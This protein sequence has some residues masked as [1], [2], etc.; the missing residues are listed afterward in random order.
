VAGE[1]LGRRPVEERGG[2]LP[3]AGEAALRRRRGIER[4]VD[5]GPSA[6]HLVQGKLDAGAELPG[7]LKGVA[8]G[9]EDLDQRMADGS[10]AGWSA[11]TSRSKGRSWCA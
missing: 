2:V 11:S 8:E 4:E 6:V 9:E 5:L 10:R 3:L 1:A 7:H